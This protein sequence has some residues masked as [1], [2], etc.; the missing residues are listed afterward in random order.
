MSFKNDLCKRCTELFQVSKGFSFGA[1]D[2]GLRGLGVE[3]LS[4]WGAGLAPLYNH[5]EFLHCIGNVQIYIHAYMAY[6]FSVSVYL[7]I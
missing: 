1:E 7:D 6:R 4:C 3:G 2:L 5:A